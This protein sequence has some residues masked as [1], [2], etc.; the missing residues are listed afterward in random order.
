[1]RERQV[2]QGNGFEGRRAIAETLPFT[3]GIGRLIV[4]SQEMVDEG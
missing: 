3:D 2:C 1:V 4:T